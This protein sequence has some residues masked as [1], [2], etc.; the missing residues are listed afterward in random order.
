MVMKVPVP[1]RFWGPVLL[2]VRY[3]AAGVLL[4]TDGIV[5][6]AAIEDGV[7]QAA[8]QHIVTGSAQKGKEISG[9]RG[10]ELPGRS[11][12]KTRLTDDPSADPSTV[13]VLPLVTKLLAREACN[14]GPQ[15]E[16]L[17]F[18]HC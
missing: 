16:F 5:A 17:L 10:A 8:F 1:P 9:G 3:D 13:T 18:Q 12:A 15:P 2:G 11:I 4:E 14:C 7:S 6:A